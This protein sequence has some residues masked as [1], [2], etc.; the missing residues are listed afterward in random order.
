MSNKIT[1][2]DK[3][4]WEE[5]ISS[6]QKLYDKELKTKNSHL[7]KS[8]SLDLHGYTLEEANNKIEIYK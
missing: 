6:E 7:I 3:K 8:R 4:A 2:K 1:D 5:F